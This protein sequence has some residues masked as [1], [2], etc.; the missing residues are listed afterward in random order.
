MAAPVEPNRA[1]LSKRRAV[2]GN[3]RLDSG[4]SFPHSAMTMES[5]T[6]T[7]KAV[8]TNSDAYIAGCS[9]SNGCGAPRSG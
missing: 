2:T 8:P 4:A 3:G 9:L 6:N 1:P 5:P 7:S